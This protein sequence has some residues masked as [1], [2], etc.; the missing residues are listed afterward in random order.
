MGIYQRQ[1]Y[2]ETRPPDR[3]LQWGAVNWLIAVNVAMYILSAVSVRFF[4]WNP[5]TGGLGLTAAD[6]VDRFMV[7]QFVTSMFLHDLQKVLHLVFNM[8]I[9]YMFGRHVERRLGVRS[10]LKLYFGAGFV[11]GISYVVFGL[12]DAPF[13]PAVGASGAVFGVIV[14]FT[15]LSPNTVVLLFFV[16]PM[17]MKWVTLLFLSFDL[18]Y[19]VFSQP[20]TTTVAHIAHLGGALFGLLYFRYAHRVQRFFLDLEIGA[21]EKA[22]RKKADAAREMEDE[23]DRLLDRVREGGLDALSE[24]ERRYLKEASER[25]RDE[26]R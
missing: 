6:V 21:R 25:L 7:W 15:C 16:I 10:F 11:A 26:G 20:G 3:R 19:F 13:T 12:F 5:V 23:V 14:Y 9:L 1:W 24:S 4:R 17:R 8:L 18:Y 2:Q 22:L